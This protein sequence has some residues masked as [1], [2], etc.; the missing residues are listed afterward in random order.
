M[1]LNTRALRMIRN[2]CGENIGALVK[3]THLF[4]HVTVYSIEITFFSSSN[5]S[6]SCWHQFVLAVSPLLLGAANFK[7]LWVGNCP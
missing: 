2:T 6:F 3:F 7:V 4:K 1:T 5:K